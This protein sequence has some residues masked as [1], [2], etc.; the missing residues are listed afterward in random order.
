MTDCSAAVSVLR[1]AAIEVALSA[2]RAAEVMVE[3]AEA[4]SP[5]AASAESVAVAAAAVASAA[6]FAV[7]AVLVFCGIL[8]VKKEDGTSACIESSETG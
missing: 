3:E 5:A 4:A 7:L 1:R 8:Q 6:A 2:E